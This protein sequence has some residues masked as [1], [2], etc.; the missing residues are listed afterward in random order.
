M[1]I[2]AGVVAGPSRQAIFVAVEHHLAAIGAGNTVGRGHEADLHAGVVECAVAIQSMVL[3][4]ADIAFEHIL[5]HLRCH[6]AEGCFSL[7]G[8]IC[9][10]N[11][12]IFFV[13]FATGAGVFGADMLCVVRLR[14]AC[15]LSRAQHTAGQQTN[16]GNQL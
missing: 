6:F 1:L 15:C 3:I 11:D 2:V 8:N 14:G 9:C 16:A 13:S 4:E 12:G 10:I 7:V 5:I